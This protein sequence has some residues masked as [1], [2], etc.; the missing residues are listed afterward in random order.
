STAPPS[1]I[2]CV[3]REAEA[4]DAIVRSRILGVN[5][6][7]AD[8]M[9][10]AD[11]FAGRHGIRGEARFEG[12]A[13]RFG[14]TGVALLE[15]ALSSFDCLV[16]QTSDCA[17]HSIFLCLVQDVRCG[18]GVPLIYSRAKFFG[19]DAQPCDYS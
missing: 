12:T 8:Q 14:S 19:L 15:G 11:R 17:T 3:N 10:I 5:V 1:L 7:S 2:V 4:H 9:H 13:W 18:D 6:L 16:A